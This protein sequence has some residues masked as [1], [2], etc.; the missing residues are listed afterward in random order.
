MANGANENRGKRI[1][2]ERHVCC[3]N[4][5]VDIHGRAASIVLDVGAY[6]RGFCASSIM[7]CGC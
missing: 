7:E 6:V 4:R 2:N 5:C 3:G 1:A